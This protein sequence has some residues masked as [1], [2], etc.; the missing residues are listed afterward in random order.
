MTA[1][2]S[3]RISYYTNISHFFAKVNKKTKIFPFSQNFFQK[4]IDKRIFFC[5]NY[6]RCNQTTFAAMAQQVEHV[7]GKDEVTGSN[8]VSSSRKGL[9]LRKVLFPFVFRIKSSKAIPRFFCPHNLGQFNRG[10]A[11]FFTLFRAASQ[12][13]PLKSVKAR[14][15]HSRLRTSFLSRYAKRCRVP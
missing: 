8:P 6:I 15:A 13:K 14:A 10:I 9:Y 2:I 3:L 4:A 12:P 5:Y 1:S 11:F 7:L